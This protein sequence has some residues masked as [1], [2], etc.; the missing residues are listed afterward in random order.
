MRNSWLWAAS[1][2]AALSLSSCAPSAPELDLS[3][4]QS[5]NQLVVINNE[6]AGVAECLVQLNRAEF[7]E[8][9]V[10]L[11]PGEAVQL[12]LDGF[13][14]GDGRRFNPLTH[15]VEDILVHCFQPTSRVA[16]FGSR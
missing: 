5:G 13:T 15:E 16:S 9:N 2:V 6:S 1:Y 10:S 3:V 8:Q 11:P 4:R 7:E 14:R 12:P